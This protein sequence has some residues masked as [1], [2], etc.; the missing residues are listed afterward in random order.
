MLQITSISIGYLEIVWANLAELP[1]VIPCEGG[2]HFYV[3]FV[4]IGHPYRG[5]GLDQLLSESRVYAAGM[6]KLMMA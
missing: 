3:C 6:T 1:G 4:G 5:A 2:V